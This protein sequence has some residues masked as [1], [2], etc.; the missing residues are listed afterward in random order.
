MDTITTWWETLTT[1][2]QIYYGI[3][4]ISTALMLV[5]TVLTLLGADAD[6]DVEV[7]TDVAA[8]GDGGSDLGLLSVRTIIAFLM[9]F[10]WAGAWFTEIGWSVLLVV[11]LAFV[12]GFILMVI[13]AWLMKLLY[14]LRQS[15]TLAFDSAVGEL[16]TVYLPIPPDKE[17]AGK[18]EVMVQGRLRVV[19]AFTNAG[20]RLENRARVRVIDVVGPNAL[21]VE[22][23]Y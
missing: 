6:V 10:G 7:D 2:L 12:I 8:G 11:P 3:G 23:E 17:K 19:D 18:V 16:A 4:L 22:P 14:G 20:A 1:G 5:Q 13:V 21:L 9:G 15:G